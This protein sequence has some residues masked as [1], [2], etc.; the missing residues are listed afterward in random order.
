[1]G[2]NKIIGGTANTLKDCFKLA[3]NKVDYIGL[4]PFQYTTTKAKLDPI[5]GLETYNKIIKN[6]PI[7]IL[8]LFLQWEESNRK[9]LFH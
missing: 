5:L 3:E 9:I 6:F 1:M 8:L 2:T 4:G 7:I